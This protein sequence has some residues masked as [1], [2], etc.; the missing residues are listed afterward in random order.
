MK[1]YDVT[2]KSRCEAK[3]EYFEVEASNFEVAKKRA[4]KKAVENGWS[5]LN[6]NLMINS[7]N[8]YDDGRFAKHNTIALW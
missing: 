2:V 4:R 6:S 5:P 7:Q 1:T 3:S 8:Y